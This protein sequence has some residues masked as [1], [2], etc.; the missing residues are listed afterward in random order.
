[1]AL[2]QPSVLKDQ[3]RLQDEQQLNTAY[4]KFTGFFHNPEI[5][6]NIERDR[7]DR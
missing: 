7:E 6:E 4:K 1:M 2:F 5:Q 3:L